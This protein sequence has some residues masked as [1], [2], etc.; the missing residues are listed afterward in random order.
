[1]SLS[2]IKQFGEPRHT[3]EITNYNK[4]MNLI[5]S[6]VKINFIFMKENFFSFNLIPKKVSLSNQVPSVLICPATKASLVQDIDAG[7]A[8]TKVFEDIMLSFYP[9]D[10]EWASRNVEKFL[11]LCPNTITATIHF[12]NENNPNSIAKFNHKNARKALR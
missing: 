10:I 1:M 12:L 3:V 2:A 4:E 5:E 8:I 11:K 9:D 7:L 6:K